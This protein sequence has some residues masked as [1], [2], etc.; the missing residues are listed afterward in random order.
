MSPQ[1]K[2]EGAPK[3]KIEALVFRVADE[4]AL[5]NQTKPKVASQ[6]CA[7]LAERSEEYYLYDRSRLEK[8]RRVGNGVRRKR[9]RKLRHRSPRSTPLLVSMHG[10][11]PS[12]P[13][14]SAW[15]MHLAI[16]RSAGSQRR[17]PAA[18]FAPRRPAPMMGPRAAPMRRPAETC[19]LE[20]PCTQL[21]RS[22]STA[23]HRP[24]TYFVALRARLFRAEE[25]GRG[26]PQLTGSTAPGRHAHRPIM[27]D[28]R[29]RR[30]PPIYGNKA[31]R[32]TQAAKPHACRL[33][34]THMHRTAL[35][36]R[37]RASRTVHMT[38]SAPRGSAAHVPDQNGKVGLPLSQ[39][40][41]SLLLYFS[42]LCF[43]F[44]SRSLTLPTN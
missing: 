42:S 10:P 41:V 9:S 30:D 24:R 38:T 6:T 18:R 27:R 25:D 17:A 8:A 33:R 7:L 43:R 1:Q 13:S 35:V 23:L 39:L 22:S 26:A 29:R 37:H 19:H 28:G 40:K 4:V 16:C 15:M 21:D 12:S 14:P 3:F 32:Q 11:G 5:C 31:P 44:F 34:A 2:V 20:M 36:L